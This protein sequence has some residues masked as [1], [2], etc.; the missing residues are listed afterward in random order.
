MVDRNLILRAITSIVQRV[1]THRSPRAQM[2]ALNGIALKPP[3]NYRSFGFASFR[4]GPECVRNVHIYTGK[5]IDV[6]L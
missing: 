6:G 3:M 2:L 5:V 4:A 1:E